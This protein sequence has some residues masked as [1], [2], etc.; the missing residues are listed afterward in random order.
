RDELFDQNIVIHE[1]QDLTPEQIEFLGKIF[2]EDIFPV[3]TPI[4]IDPAHPFPFIPN[5]GFSL[6]FQLERSADNTHMTALVRVPANLDRF[7]KLPTKAIS[8][9]RVEMV[10]I[11]TMV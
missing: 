10:T 6:A 8:D 9:R 1:A 4:A 5:L 7:V 3:L 2:R 11:E